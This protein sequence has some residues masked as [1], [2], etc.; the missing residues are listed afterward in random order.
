MKEENKRESTRYNSVLLLN[1]VCLDSD[2]ERLG[3]G[4]ARTLDISG[5]G[6]KIETHQPIDA[7][8]IVFL[9]IGI[10]EDIFDV[11]GRVIYCNRNPE[12]R[13]ESGVEFYELDSE[14]FW[15][16]KRFIEAYETTKL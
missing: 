7:R 11:K 14:I 6:A 1:Y 3:Q 12:G 16:L 4:M 13:F 5:T 15:K 2:G 8:Y 9:S 10:G